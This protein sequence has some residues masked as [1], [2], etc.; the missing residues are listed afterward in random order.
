L[1]Q[2]LHFVALALS[3]NK[4]G[5]S[6]HK[7]YTG[8]INR[9]SAPSDP[10]SV[11]PHIG[12]CE[13]LLPSAGASE[14]PPTAIT[15]SELEFSGHEPADDDAPTMELFGGEQS[16]NAASKTS[17]AQTG[18]V[19]GSRYRLEGVIGRGASCVVFRA[20]DLHRD[21]SEI[22]QAEF[23]AIKL[24]RPQQ[25][26]N[27]RAIARLKRE[28]AQMQCLSHPGIAR[29]FGLDC[30]G[31]IWFMHMEL[32]AGRTVKSRMATPGSIENHLEVIGACCKALEHSHALGILHGDL[33]PSNVMVGDDG[34][35]KLIDFGSTPGPDSHSVT[36]SDLT[37]AATPLYASPQILAGAAAER[38][39]DV[40]SLACL[41]Y[42][43]LSGG[44]HPFGGHPSFEHGRAK[45][46]PTYVRSIPVELFE[47][48]ERALSAE[49]ERRPASASEFLRDLSDADRRRCA[50]AANAAMAASE[51]DG[52]AHCPQSLVPAADGVPTS[53][54]TRLL[55]PGRPGA[56]RLTSRTGR[57]RTDLDLFGAGHGFHRRSPSSA[58]LAALVF[59]VV[60][61]GV[62][63]RLDPA[64]GMLHNTRMPIVAASA[65]PEL[66]ALPAQ[67]AQDPQAAVTPHDA[68]VVSFEA[69][70]VRASAGQ[71]LVA[72]SVKRLRAI[73]NRAAFVW[74][75][76][77]GT[78]YPG[79][80]YELTKPQT[81]RFIE[82]QS[83]RTLF[84]PL[85]NTG[86]A[87]LARGP[88]SFTVVLEQVAGGPTLG[89][90]ARAT[91]ALDP[92]PA[93]GRY[94]AYQVR[95]DR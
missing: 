26:A 25:R 40:F 43:M 36:G 91:V 4:I 39:D 28:F 3:T 31:D 9:V 70:T 18:F 68:G 20:R 37:T 93:S 1:L 57:L 63:L 15:R 82:G 50:N 54:F 33:K 76:E 14:S 88:R 10:G 7:R 52:P 16:F 5:L 83:V 75:V 74:R 61:A 23:V 53:T 8:A 79:V 49:R 84:I 59:A 55:R 47:V 44:Q 12:G 77:R 48:I 21:S 42:S 78:A 72:I 69:A 81:V 71:S 94:V 85:I 67:T 46:S 87:Q 51:D 38:R 89:R 19:L 41:S 92:P 2:R 56:R 66:P 64:S 27:P 80:D 95:A 35:V 73:S 86:M 62:V 6:N 60:G 22:R 30:D 65:L 13:D 58:R 29:V 45:V 24:L 32:V 34:A 11:P 17:A 90:Y